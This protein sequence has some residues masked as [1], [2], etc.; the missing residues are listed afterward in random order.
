MSRKEKK[1]LA[2]L[3]I[4][5]PQEAAPKQ[6]ASSHLTIASVCKEP[7]IQAPII[8]MESE[9]EMLQEVQLLEPATVV[10]MADVPVQ[11]SSTTSQYN[12]SLGILGFNGWRNCKDESW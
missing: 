1:K 12:A 8:E 5:P 10:A 3:K 7:E 2:A 9:P 6:S 11:Q 4:M